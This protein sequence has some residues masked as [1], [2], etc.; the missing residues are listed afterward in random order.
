[1]KWFVMAL[2]SLW[3]GFAA[4][5]VLPALYDVAGVAGTDVLKIRAA[6]DA[7]SAAMGS[8]ASYA[9]AVEVVAVSPDGKWAQIN[10]GEGAGWVALRFLHKP[11]QSD[12][13]ALAFNLECSGTEPFWTLFVD[14]AD[15]S[16]HI[17]TPDE[18]GPEID[19]TGVWP[20]TAAQPTATV[21]FAS[22]E[23]SGIAL[24]R[25]QTCSDGMSDQAFGIS[26]DLFQAAGPNRP[27]Q[28][29]HGC[30]RLAP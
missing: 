20:G 3:P 2:C 23:A 10:A 9:K 25:W 1:M 17:N 6:A 24:L 12:W 4:A 8:L 14:P 29:L 19:I 21:Q 30:C 15:K 5:Q 22:K 27:A 16:V 11:D 18:E 7:S 28:I 13:F 26:L